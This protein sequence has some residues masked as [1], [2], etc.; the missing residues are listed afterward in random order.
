MPER[1]RATVYIHAI[2]I[3]RQLTQ[4]GESLRGKRFVQL[5]EADVLEREAG[6]L[7][8]F[9]NRGDGADPEPLRLNTR[10]RNATKRPMGV[11]LALL[12]ARPTSRSPPPRR[13]SFAKSCRP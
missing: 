12:P 4:A 11:R 5:D 7:E 3:N 9:T 8:H 1:D 2:R 6:K 10:G 13:R